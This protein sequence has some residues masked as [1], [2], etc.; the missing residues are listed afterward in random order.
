VPA[1]IIARCTPSL[2]FVSLWWSRAVETILYPDGCSGRTLFYLRDHDGGKIAEV[3]NGIVDAVLKYDRD[4]QEV[5]HLFWVD[6]D[7]L[8]FPGCLIQLLKCSEQYKAEIVSGVYFTKQAVSRPL[9]YPKRNES[10]DI[11]W[12]NRQYPVFGHGMGLTLV[13][14][15]VYRRM[16]DLGLPMDCYGRPQ[17]YHTTKLMDEVYED[18]KGIIH[19]GSTEDFYFLDHAEKLGYQPYIDTTKHAFG[20]HYQPEYCCD[21]GWQHPSVKMSRTHKRDNP[22]HKMALEDKG[23]PV[24]QWEQW[25]SGECIRWQTPDGEVVWN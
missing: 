7:V 10:S 2:G 1:K 20:F 4:V 15:G 18:E 8:V 19:L 12:P 16:L 13:E 5:S 11:F 17:W 22:T 24:E 3:R 25:T 9:V 6:D 21:C 14:V 23:Y